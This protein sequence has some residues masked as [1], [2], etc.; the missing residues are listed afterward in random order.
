M[1]GAGASGGARGHEG[2]PGMLR[3]TKHVMRTALA[4]CA[5]VLLIA[6][7][8]A[9]AAGAVQAREADC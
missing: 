4:A 9:A 3:T 7:F 2:G 6:A 1:E 5:T 8:S